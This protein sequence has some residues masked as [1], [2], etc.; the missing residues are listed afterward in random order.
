MVLY[1]KEDKRAVRIWIDQKKFWEQ[2]DLT[3]I[4]VNHYQYSKSIV[5]REWE[6]RDWRNLMKILV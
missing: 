4:D 1:I 6:E 3:T 5:K 2:P